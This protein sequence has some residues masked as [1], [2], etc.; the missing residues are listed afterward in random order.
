MNSLLRLSVSRTAAA[1]ARLRRCP[2]QR[3]FTPPAAL[4]STTRLM[5]SK[6]N[7]QPDMTIPEGS[8]YAVLGVGRSVDPE[9][10]KAIYKSLAREYHPD[11]HQ[12]EGREEA[13]QKFQEISEAYQTLSDPARRAIYDADIDKAKSAAE[14][15]KAAKRFR[16]GT[17]NTEVPD[18]K[19]RLRNAKREDP[20]MPPHIIAGTL[21]FVTGNFIMVVNWLG[22]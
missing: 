11:R 17:W 18:V 5:S 19:A 2:Q 12:G 20:G 3:V 9:S 14:A 21:L 4:W 7:K 16:A 10:L 22:G 15:A 13:E 6:P 8:A 1:A